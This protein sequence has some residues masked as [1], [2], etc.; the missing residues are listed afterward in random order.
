MICVLSVLRVGQNGKASDE[1][2]DKYTPSSHPVTLPRSVEPCLMMQESF[3][4]IKQNLSEALLIL[5]PYRMDKCFG[6]VKHPVY[7]LRLC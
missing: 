7:E 3:R 6:S 5:L 2:A 1:D 4:H